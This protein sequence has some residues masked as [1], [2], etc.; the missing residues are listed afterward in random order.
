MEKFTRFFSHHNQ[1]LVL[2][3]Y[4]TLCHIIVNLSKQ[5]K[6]KNVLY[7]AISSRDLECT[8]RYDTSALPTASQS[9][10]SATLDLPV[11]NTVTQ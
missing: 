9:K 2:G 5:V 6:R 10:P 11:S 7:L 8:C 1:L 3:H 4:Q